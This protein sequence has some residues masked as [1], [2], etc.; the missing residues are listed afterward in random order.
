MWKT[1]TNLDSIPYCLVKTGRLLTANRFAL[2]QL[3]NDKYS[4][5]FVSQPFLN[6]PDTIGAKVFR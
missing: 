1:K 3:S 5:S 4:L 2:T 6:L